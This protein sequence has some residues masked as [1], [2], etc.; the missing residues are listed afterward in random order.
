MMWEDVFPD[1]FVSD[2]SGAPG[3]LGYSGAM[4][5]RT[6]RLGEVVV[7]AALVVLPLLACKNK[8]APADPEA[9]ATA[10]APKSTGPCPDG[11]SV[12]PGPGELNPAITAL[13]EEQFDT[14]EKLL[15]TMKT[16]YPNS[17]SVRVWRAE[18]ALLNKKKKYAERADD[19]L[20]FYEEALKLHDKGCA[21]PETDHY[22]LRLGFA[23]AYLRKKDGDGAM[24]HLDVAKKNW[25]NS[26]EVFYNVARA[27][28]TKND[29]EACSAALEQCFKLAKA[30]KRP[31]FLREHHSLD[32]WIERSGTQS[33]FKPLSYSKR[34]QI[35]KAGKGEE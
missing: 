27:Q 19:A 15:E 26:P 12:D 6:P 35:I 4:N 31:T 33:E 17:A 28:C 32:E 3:G 7:A 30:L 34:Q 18:T 5:P 29:V 1:Y 13:K 20:V 23:W 2:F 10:A 21:L 22:Y 16:K 11:K 14:A 8:D 9:V 24:K 25:A